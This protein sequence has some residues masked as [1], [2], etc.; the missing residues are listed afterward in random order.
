M[1]SVE[2]TKVKCSHSGDTLRHPLNMS[3]NINNENQD[4]KTGTVCVGCTCGGGWV[5]EGD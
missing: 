3:L 4:C 5:N 2:Q 1:E